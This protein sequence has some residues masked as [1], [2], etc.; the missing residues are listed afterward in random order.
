[1]ARF[2][3]KP[4]PWI[5]VGNEFPDIVYHCWGNYVWIADRSDPESTRF[6]PIESKGKSIRECI[7]LLMS[8]FPFRSQ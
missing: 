4:A 3:S 8:N 6:G 7:R 1:M 5:P 2:K